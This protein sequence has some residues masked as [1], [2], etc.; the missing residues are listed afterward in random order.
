MRQRVWKRRYLRLTVE[1]VST[2]EKV[3]ETMTKNGL[4]PSKKYLLK[5]ASIAKHGGWLVQ[6]TEQ[7]VVVE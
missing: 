1:E 6:W 2:T 7:P 5:K 4:D 3:E